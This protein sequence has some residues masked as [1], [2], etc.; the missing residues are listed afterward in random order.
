MMPLNEGKAC[1]SH[2]YWKLSR[3]N[4]SLSSVAYSIRHRDLWRLRRAPNFNVNLTPVNE[5]M[6]NL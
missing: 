6:L 3:S 1:P 2:E 5:T 4:H